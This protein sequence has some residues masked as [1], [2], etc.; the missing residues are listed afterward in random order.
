MTAVARFVG[1]SLVA[2]GILVFGAAPQAMAANTYSG[3]VVVGHPVTA[4]AGGVSE[5]AAACSPG[6]AVDGID[7]QWFALAA[8]DPGQAATLTMDP[9]LDADVWFYD[10]ACNFINDDSMAQAFVGETE[11][12]RVPAAAAYAVVDGFAGTGTSRSRSGSHAPERRRDAQDWPIW[13]MN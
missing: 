10:A 1:C 13:L 2:A 6:G 5:I 11:S 12:S 8:T 7:G 9:T 4:A 3:S